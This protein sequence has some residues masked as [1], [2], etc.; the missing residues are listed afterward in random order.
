MIFIVLKSLSEHMISYDDFGSLNTKVD[1]FMVTR[2]D[3][4]S[5]ELNWDYNL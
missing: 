3:D 2:E 4:K 5:K 1:V